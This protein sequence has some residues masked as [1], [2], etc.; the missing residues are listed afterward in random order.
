M[1]DQIH[2]F[3][4]Q[5]LKPVVEIEPVPAPVERKMINP[6][7]FAPKSKRWDDPH[8]AGGKIYFALLAGPVVL[9]ARRI[10]KRASEAETYAARLKERWIRLYDAAVVAMVETSVI[11]ERS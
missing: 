4:L 2:E 11:P 3:G 8:F 9:R 10:F 5:D 6:N 1:T 7:M